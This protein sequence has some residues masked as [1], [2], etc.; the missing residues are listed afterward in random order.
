MRV[1]LEIFTEISLRGANCLSRL[2]KYYQE[3]MSV[4]Q[5][6]SFLIEVEHILI[7]NISQFS[8]IQKILSTICYI[9]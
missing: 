1:F 7:A 9:D 5:S 4:G 2:Y 3:I 8:F 6:F